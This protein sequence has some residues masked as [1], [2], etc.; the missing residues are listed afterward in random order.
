M[1]YQT[2][3]LTET[4]IEARRLWVEALRD[5]TNKQTT[6]R[7]GDAKDGYCCLGL[8]CEVAVQNGVI[9]EY[10]PNNPLPPQA[11][12]DWLGLKEHAGMTVLNSIEEGYENDTVPLTTLNDNANYRF[13]FNQ[14]ADVIEAGALD[15]P[16][17][18]VHDD[19]P[20]SYSPPSAYD[21]LGGVTV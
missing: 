20:L 13:T 5:D 12:V 10:T 7:L 8:A 1:T 14:I 17:E 15:Q 3:N 2:V 18:Y 16:I 11:V 4:Q 21:V 6:G 9:E 19:Y